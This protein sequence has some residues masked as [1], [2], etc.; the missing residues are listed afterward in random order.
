MLFLTIDINNQ[1]LH[2]SINI[3]ITRTIFQDQHLKMTSHSKPANDIILNS[4]KTVIIGSLG[5]EHG[6]TNQKSNA[7]QNV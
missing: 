6:R 3:M 5:N 4:F 2:G 7:S 1:E